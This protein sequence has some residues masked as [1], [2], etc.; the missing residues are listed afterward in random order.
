[1]L[2]SHSGD[3]K[4]RFGITYMR[5][6]GSVALNQ[7]NENSDIDVLVEMPPK[8]YNICAAT[9]YL[10]EMLGCHV[11]LIRKHSNIR[12]FFMNQI[13]KYGIDIY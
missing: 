2:K 13:M 4:E 7:H 3:L 5:L 1:M 9:E 6:F 12:P 8:A 10:E 11:D